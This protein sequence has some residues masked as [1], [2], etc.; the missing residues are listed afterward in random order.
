MQVV[1]TGRTDVEEYFAQSVIREFKKLAH[2]ISGLRQ[3]R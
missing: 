2:T 3:T 1:T